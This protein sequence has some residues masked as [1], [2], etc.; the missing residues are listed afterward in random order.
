MDG[1]YGQYVAAPANHVFLLP[2]DVPMRFAPMV[3]MYGLGCHVL[4]RGSR[5]GD[6]I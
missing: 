5:C 3:E 4:S 1:G 2:D 6:P